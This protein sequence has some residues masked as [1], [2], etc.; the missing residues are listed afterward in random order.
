MEISGTFDFLASQQAVWDALMDPNVIAQAIPGVKEMMPVDGEPN[1]WRAIAKVGVASI[2]GTYSGIIKMSE[3]DAPTR[4]RLTVNGEG[5]QSIIGGTAVMELSYDPEKQQT[6]LIWTAEANISGK[7]ASIGQRLIK[8]AAGLLSRQFFQGI[9]KQVP[10]P[11][12]N[13]PS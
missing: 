3:V 6:H 9:A 11:E 10:A 8:S 4:Y 12:N 13:A 2:S 7:L 1:T 5:Q